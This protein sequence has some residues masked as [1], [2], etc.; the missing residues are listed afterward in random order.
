VLEAN[1][2]WLRQR[3]EALGYGLPPGG[4]EPVKGWKAAVAA[5]LD[6]T[7][8]AVGQ[9]WRGEMRLPPEWVAKP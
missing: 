8:A 5:S 6:V 2:L 4:A 9:V 3:A 1:R 7:A